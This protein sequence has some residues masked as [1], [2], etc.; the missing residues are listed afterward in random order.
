MGGAK[1]AQRATDWRLPIWVIGMRRLALVVAIP[2]SLFGATALAQEPST[3]EL[4]VAALSDPEAIDRLRQVSPLAGE[5]LEGSPAEVTSRLETLS[6]QTLPDAEAQ[7]DIAEASDRIESILAGP[8]YDTDLPPPWVQWWDDLVARLTI[9]FT[10]LINGL[11]DDFSPLLTAGVLLV[12]GA[13]VWAIVK[14][15]RGRVRE[16]ERSAIARRRDERGIDPDRLLQLATDAER[17]G[18]LE[19][20]LRYLYLAGL[21]RLAESGKVHLAPG[22]TSAEVAEELESSDFQ[23]VWFRH[24][25][26]VFGE[27]PMKLGDL[28]EARAEWS[29]LLEQV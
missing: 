28:S 16:A 18:D 8:R 2:L 19:R 22:T 24:D 7:E 1:T 3:P 26:V 17:S 4:A 25:E 10:R 6:A 14:L 12:V 27:R 13:A 9:W 21:G 11:V 15:A 29:K 20:A 23:R 5:A